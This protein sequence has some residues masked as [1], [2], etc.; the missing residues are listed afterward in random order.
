MGPYNKDYPSAQEAAN[1][2]ESQEDVGPQDMG[3]LLKRM[4]SKIKEN[5]RG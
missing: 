1:Q 4:I 2:E 5:E 3:G